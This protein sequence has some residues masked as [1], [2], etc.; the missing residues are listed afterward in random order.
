MLVYQ[1]VTPI[2]A[3]KSMVKVNSSRPTAKS[4]DAASRVQWHVGF[5]V[6]QNMS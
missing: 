2:F 6:S 1:R 4:K 5:E 3:V